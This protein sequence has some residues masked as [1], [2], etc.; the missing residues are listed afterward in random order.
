MILGKKLILP[1]ATTCLFFNACQEKA[2]K[3][4]PNFIFYITD[5]ISFNDLG[6]YGNTA[7]HT[8]HLDS[9]A[10]EGLL[11]TEAY[12]TTS[13]CSPSRSGIITGRYPHNT[14]AP[15]LHTNMPESQ[16][17]FPDLLQEAGYYTALSGKNHMGPAVSRAFDT[18][19]TG[20]GPGLQEDWVA[21]MR[22]RPK[23]KPFFFWFASVDA[24]RPW[25]IDSTAPVFAPE[26]VWVPPFLFDGP[27]T[28][29]DLT[30]YY[31][32]V[33]R[34][35]HYLGEIIKELKKQGISENTYVIFMSDNGRPFPRSKTRLY[36]SGIK[37]PFIVWNPGTV[38]A[39][40]T[41]ALIS[42]I[43]VAATV[44]DLAK[45]NVAPT[46]QGVSFS[47]VLDDPASQIRN[48]AFAEH[49]WHVFR[50]HERMV[51][52]GKYMY[53]KNAYLE[54]MSMSRES[55]PEFPAGVELWNAWEEGLTHPEQ[56]D[57]F[58][59]P[60]P[61][62]ELYNVAEDPFQFNNLATDPAYANELETMRAVLAEWTEA[63]GDN[64][65]QNPTPDREDIYRTPN[66]EFS[67]HQE[68]PGDATGADTITATGPVFIEPF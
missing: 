26:D 15:E 66:P 24:H 16:V 43:D 56:E 4:Q 61:E 64:V 68:M 18:I 13:S 29:E 33:S 35:D 20:K 48:V 30:G 47:A 1:L 5:D 44:L 3:P 63:T 32:E 40:K 52:H 42:A 62:E 50:S 46:I 55:A 14:G 41:D 49:N 54:K 25:N 27:K 9:L 36:D 22:E 60:R 65:P 11:F 10:M 7:A 6:C 53:I 34:A 38:N 19:S 23:E 67:H 21:L 59:N 31:H 12:L 37:T 57:I 8:P 28:R 45:V 2:E 39:G 58:Q 17:F 51:R